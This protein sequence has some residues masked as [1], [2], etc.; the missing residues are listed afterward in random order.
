MHSR[1]K[2]NKGEDI[3]CTF[4]EGKGFSIVAR[5]YLKRWG[6]LD[7]VATKDK[8]IHFF[9]V[10]SVT[11]GEKALGGHKPEDNVHGLK[12]RSI[13]R[14]IETYIDDHGISADREIYFHVL[15][16]F[17]DI[18]RRTARVKWIENIIL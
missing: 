14:M 5:N 13:R 15:C 7:I 17:M 6:E 1:A 10:K 4:L 16:V 9:E 18:Q 3:A 11:F 8:A 2:G 12:A